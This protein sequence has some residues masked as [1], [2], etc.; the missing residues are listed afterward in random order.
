MAFSS[1]CK[2]F[3][4]LSTSKF[5]IS[6]NILLNGLF[7]GVA[8]ILAIVKTP[9]SDWVSS[10]IRNKDQMLHRLTGL[11]YLMIL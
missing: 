2:L 7:H 9:S 11:Y 1:V 6:Y 8:C 10:N 5:T 3:L 4:C